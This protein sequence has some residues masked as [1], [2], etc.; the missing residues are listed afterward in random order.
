MVG[1]HG[2]PIPITAVNWA[3]AIL[4]S[5]P[6]RP[7]SSTS[8]PCDPSRRAR[9]MALPSPRSRSADGG[10]TWQTNSYYSGQLGIRDLAFDPNTPGVVYLGTLRSIEK[11]TDDGLTF[12]AL[13]RP[14]YQYEAD[15][16]LFDPRH[17]GTLYAC[18]D[19]GGGL[20]QST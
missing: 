18:R 4:P 12:A 1:P 13:P 2:R 17:P 5:T 15:S 11:S 7:A 16:I 10:A 3:S 19:Y 14:A 6:T 20:F 9:T 8:A